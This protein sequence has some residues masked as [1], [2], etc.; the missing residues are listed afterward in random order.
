MYE[1]VH[2]YLTGNRFNRFFFL[3]KYPLSDGKTVH[4]TAATFEATLHVTSSY[5]NQILNSDSNTTGH[6]HFQDILK[7]D[8]F[9]R[10]PESNSYLSHFRIDFKFINQISNINI[11]QIHFDINYFITFVICKSNV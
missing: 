1:K 7:T 8:S 11:N 4:N 5:L 3:V 6:T 9:T 10:V 2:G